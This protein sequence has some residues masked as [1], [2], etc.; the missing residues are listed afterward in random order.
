MLQC[1]EKTS[2]SPHYH[3][4]VLTQA[5]IT[6]TITITPRNPLIARSLI[7]LLALARQNQGTKIAV[8]S[9]VKSCTFLSLQNASSLNC[10]HHGTEKNYLNP[11]INTWVLDTTV[12]TPLPHSE[13]FW[14]AFWMLLIEGASKRTKEDNRQNWGTNPWYNS[15]PIHWKELWC[16]ANLLHY[17]TPYPPLNWYKCSICTWEQW[18]K[19]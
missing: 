1:A 10:R 7:H 14:L 15:K 9:G 18:D 4:S 11:S 5:A 8:F 12:Q 16:P 17:F 19:N 2:P 13:C 3:W 6:N